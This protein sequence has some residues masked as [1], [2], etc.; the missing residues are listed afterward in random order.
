M[1]SWKDSTGTLTCRGSCSN[2]GPHCLARLFAVQTKEPERKQKCF[3]QHVGLPQNV[4]YDG[5]LQKYILGKPMIIQDSVQLI[6]LK[7]PHFQLPNPSLTAD[8]A[9][10]AQKLPRDADRSK[11]GAAKCSEFQAGLPL[12][13]AYPG[14]RDSSTTEEYEE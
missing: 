8:D 14:S 10:V 6:T 9:D 4:A 11:C 7:L 1:L 2:C 12:P 13:R 5:I 3:I